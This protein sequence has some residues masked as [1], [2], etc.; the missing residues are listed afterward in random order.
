MS[1]MIW[2]F[3]RDEQ[4]IALDRAVSQLV[5]ARADRM[6]AQERLFNALKKVEAGA[7]V[8]NGDEN[9]KEKECKGC[10]ARRG[11]DSARQDRKAG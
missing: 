7:I 5:Q 2:P 8:L 1:A 4:A 3:K 6:V 9:G 11:Q 10:Q